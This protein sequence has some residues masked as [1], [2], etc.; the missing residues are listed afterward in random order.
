MS[1]PVAETSFGSLLRRWR[2]ARRMS[3]LQLALEAAVSARHISFLE[4]GRAEPSREMTLKLAN[5]L[6]VPFREQNVLLQAAGFASVFRETSL[7]T[8]EMANVLRA[9]EWIL[10]AHEP[11]RALAMTRHW[12]V[13][14]ANRPQAAVLTHLTNRQIAPLTVLHTPRPNLLRLLFGAELRSL[15]VNWETVAQ[16]VLQRVHREA[17]WTRDEELAALGRELATHIP[18][19]SSVSG[20]SAGAGSVVIPIEL[21]SGNDV[22]RFFSTLTTFGAPHDIT[23]QELRVEAFFPADDRTAQRIREEYGALETG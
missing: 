10:R 5:A 1:L 2:S 8:P 15:L 3:Q 13:V 14:M 9:L 23:L 7:D 22:L 20:V 16:V 17:F 4:S 18:A 11:F 6:Q 12:D 21:R 19:H